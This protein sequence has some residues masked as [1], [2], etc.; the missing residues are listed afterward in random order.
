MATVKLSLD[1]SQIR[2]EVTCQNVTKQDSNLEPKSS[3]DPLVFALQSCLKPLPF[4]DCPQMSLQ[5]AQ[6]DYKKEPDCISNFGR[7]LASHGPHTA[8]SL[9]DNPP[10]P[11][12]QQ[13]QRDGD[14]LTC[15]ELQKDAYSRDPVHCSTPIGPTW[16]E[17]KDMHD[18]YW[19]DTYDADS[20]G[21]D[22]ISC[23]WDESN[24]TDDS[25]LESF[26][27]ASTED[28]HYVGPIAFRRILSGTSGALVRDI[29]SHIYTCLSLLIT[30]MLGVFLFF[31]A[32]GEGEE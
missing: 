17:S 24:N 22:E 25:R 29:S 19:A 3:G 14:E 11:V 27:A 16:T 18:E 2:E 8:P 13:Q 30:Y 12:K 23:L 5:L 20:E 28:R 26:R 21:I 31:I 1:N 4:P 32:T 10:P 9:V 15:T 6:T 7:T